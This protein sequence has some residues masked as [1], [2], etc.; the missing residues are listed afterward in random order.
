[1]D[2]QRHQVGMFGTSLVQRWI[3]GKPQ[4]ASKPKDGGSHAISL[5]VLGLD[6]KGA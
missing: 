3:V 1:M 4:I 6:A 2:I 5:T